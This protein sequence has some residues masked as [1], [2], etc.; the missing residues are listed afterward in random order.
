MHRGQP[1][2]AYQI[3]YV[4]SIVL[5]F[6][7]ADCA[8]VGLLSA[9]VVCEQISSFSQQRRLPLMSKLSLP[10]NTCNRSVH[11]GHVNPSPTHSRVLS[12]QFSFGLHLPI[13]SDTPPPTPMRYEHSCALTLDVN[14]EHAIINDE[15][16]DIF[17]EI[18]ALLNK[19]IWM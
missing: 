16:N 3:R 13:R 19:L 6:A 2:L 9:F 14:N 17:D 15:Y 1:I 4:P 5:S 7:I 8:C 11:A 18:C 12:H 10:Q